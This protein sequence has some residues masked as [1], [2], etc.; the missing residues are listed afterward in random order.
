MLFRSQKWKRKYCR[1]FLDFP[2]ARMNVLHEGGEGVVPIVG[3]VIPFIAG[4]K[5]NAI[6]LSLRNEIGNLNG[7]FLDCLRGIREVI[8]Y[9][10]Q[11][12]TVQEIEDT[13][14]E[15]LDKQR[16][17]RKQ[18]ATVA[19]MT[20]VLIVI[21]G[22]CML[23]LAGLLCYMEKIS[24]SEGFIACLTIISTFGPFI[25]IAN[26]GNTLSQQRDRKSVV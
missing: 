16:R 2:A 15:L 20:D 7:Q 1:I 24:P 13:T 21:S 6:A 14:K 12:S 17:L 10:V 11:E 18:G 25:A 19:G 23:L 22:I 9:N 3:I 4:K 5:G 8:Q 26:L